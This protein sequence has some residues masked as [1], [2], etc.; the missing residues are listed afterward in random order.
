MTDGILLWV[1]LLVECISALFYTYIT[2]RIQELRSVSRTGVLMI[3]AGAIATA[4]TGVWLP[5]APFY[6]MGAN[7][8]W[9][10]GCFARFWRVGIGLPLLLSFLH[11][12]AVDLWA[13]IIRALIRW[14]YPDMPDVW[15]DFWILIGYCLILLTALLILSRG[16][17]CLDRFLPHSSTKRVFLSV[18]VPLNLLGFIAMLVIDFYPIEGLSREGFHLRE[19][20]AALLLVAIVVVRIIYDERKA[21]DWAELK[22]EQGELIRR[23]YRELVRV[24]GEHA[25]LFHD[26]HRHFRLLKQM[27]ADRDYAGAAQYLDDLEPGET[28]SLRPC[29]TGDPVMDYL[30][31]EKVKRAGGQD[32]RL[33]MHIEYPAQLRIRR[34]DLCVILSNLMDNALEAA[35]RVPNPAERFVT[36]NLRG[37]ERMLIIKV[38]N[39]Y[40]E[41]LRRR[42]AWFRS[43]KT[44]DG[45][46]GW[47]LSSVQ[48]IAEKYQGTVTVTH[49]SGRFCAVAVLSEP[50]EPDS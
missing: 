37:V 17:G 36:L 20:V 38:E 5:V 18:F 33:D 48:M 25:R 29:R 3:C 50:D 35:A 6:W 12:M 47:G 34:P 24:Y 31:H 14:M 4:L 9:R 21:R 10:A 41:E 26:M 22:A 13:F 8:L 19:M 32:I 49:A 11:E 42:G 2:F 44:D 15:T 30:L 46:H 28:A 40:T 43:T 1:A 39:S 7:V 45:L 16:F 27:L 23:D